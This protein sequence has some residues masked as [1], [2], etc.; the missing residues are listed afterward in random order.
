MKKKLVHHLLVIL[1]I[2]SNLFFTG[3]AV[4]RQSAQL[5]L[6]ASP[7]HFPEE[8][9]LATLSPE[10]LNSSFTA[11]SGSSSFTVKMSFRV[12]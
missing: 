6:K 8:A 4:K 3:C 10:R 1:T 9:A 7:W 12:L 2:I 5:L 11:P